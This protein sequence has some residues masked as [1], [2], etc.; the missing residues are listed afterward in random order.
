[1]ERYTIFEE[2]KFMPAVFLPENIPAALRKFRNSMKREEQ[3]QQQFVLMKI[4]FDKPL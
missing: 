3:L 1:M 2:Y 4:V